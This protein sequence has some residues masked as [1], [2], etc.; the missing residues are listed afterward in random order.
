MGLGL[1]PGYTHEVRGAGWWTISCLC[2]CLRWFPS[3]T[4]ETL[5][6]Y[7]KRPCAVQQLAAILVRWRQG[8]HYLG[9]GSCHGWLTQ[10]IITVIV[11]PQWRRGD[12][13]LETELGSG[14][15]M[16]GKMEM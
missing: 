7:Y 4:A 2:I 5:A 16:R 11:L 3:S 13:Y 14:P 9:E 8:H 1:S 10:R 12:C 6:G 15:V